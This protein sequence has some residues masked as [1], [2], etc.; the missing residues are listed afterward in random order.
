MMGRVA[1][2]SRGR[3]VRAGFAT[4]SLL[5]PMGERRPA[6][7]GVKV[8]GERRLPLLAFLHDLGLG[9]KLEPDVTK[10]QSRLEREGSYA[11]PKLGYFGRHTEFK[12]R[13]YQSAHGLLPTVALMSPRARC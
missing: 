6:D 8:L 13:E 12:S 10:L 5:L 3:E 7:A 4:P 1:V 11:G 9:A 2:L